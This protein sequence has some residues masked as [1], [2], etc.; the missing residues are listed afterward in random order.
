MLPIF[1]SWIVSPVMCAIITV[2]LFFCI[3]MFILRS[4]HGFM[5]AFYVSISWSHKCISAAS[6]TPQSHVKFVPECG[7]V[8]LRHYNSVSVSS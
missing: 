8:E 5:R 1:L 7:R 3:R 2:I 4:P 6:L